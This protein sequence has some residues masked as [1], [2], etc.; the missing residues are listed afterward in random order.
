[1]L[2]LIYDPL[3]KFIVMEDNPIDSKDLM[4]GVPQEFKQIF[5]EV[6]NSMQQQQM[7]EDDFFEEALE[8]V[9]L[10]KKRPS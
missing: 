3:N 5:D 8:D 7:G 6:S 9:Q 10:N 2:Q 4:H 1:M